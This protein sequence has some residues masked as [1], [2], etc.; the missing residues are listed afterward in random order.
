MKPPPG[1]ARTRRSLAEGPARASADA[2]ARSAVSEAG[3]ATLAS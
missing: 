3:Q 1:T 2:R